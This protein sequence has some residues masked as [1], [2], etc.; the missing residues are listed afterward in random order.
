[1]KYKKKIFLN[2]IQ[3]TLLIEFYK[4]FSNER[5]LSYAYSIRNAEIIEL[6]LSHLNTIKNQKEDKSISTFYL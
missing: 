2:S 3:K 6:L 1:M 5:A 4:Y